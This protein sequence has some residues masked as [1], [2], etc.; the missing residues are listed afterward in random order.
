MIKFQNHINTDDMQNQNEVLIKIVVDLWNSQVARTT[1]MI[2][3]YNDE[4]LAKEIAPGKNTGI[5]LLG[6]LTA[7]HDLLFRLLDLGSV[8]H[9]ELEEV[10]IK[11]PD[12]S[13]LKKPDVQTLRRYW[14][15][16]NTLLSSKLSALSIGQWFEKHTSVSADDFMKEPHRNRLNVI[17]SRANHLN[18]HMGQLALLKK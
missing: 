2:E 6:H 18:Y 17:L 12:K 5:Y 8:M 7:V 14:N 4:Q 10:F 13:E 16:V 15:E 11:N 9:P 3:G 1:K